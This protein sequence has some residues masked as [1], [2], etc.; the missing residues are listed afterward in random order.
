MLSRDVVLD[1][2]GLLGDFLLLVW[3]RMSTCHARGVPGAR[4]PI[5]DSA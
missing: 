2:R 5:F 4:Q 3:P 1:T